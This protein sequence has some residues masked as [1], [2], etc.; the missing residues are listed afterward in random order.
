MDDIS[1]DQL[2]DLSAKTLK[3]LINRGI[4]EV[5]M[6]TKS[7]PETIE[8]TPEYKKHADLKGQ[9]ISIGEAARKYDTPHQTISRWKDRG[10]IP[11]LGH[12]SNRRIF[13]DEAY[14]AYC[15]E[16]KENRPGSGKWL[17]DEDG[18]PYVPETT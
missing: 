12:G 15:V 8:E 11:V 7:L 1:Q 17:F 10:F 6:T 2:D 14:V 16:V 9:K 4:I 13:L 3:S 18:L 5:T